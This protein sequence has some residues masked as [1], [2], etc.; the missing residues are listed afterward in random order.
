MLTSGFDPT[1]KLIKLA[2]ELGSDR[3]K[4]REISLSRGQEEVRN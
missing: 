4:C 2:D 3:F 1:N